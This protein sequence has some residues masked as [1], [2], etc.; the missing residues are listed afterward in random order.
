MNNQ[1]DKPYDDI[2][3]LPHPTSARHPRMSLNDRAAQFAPF[4][5]LTGHEEAIEETARLTDRPIALTDEAKEAL[6]RTLRRLADRLSA[7][8]GRAEAPAPTVTATYFVP[9]SRKEGGVYRTVIGRVAEVDELKR[10]LV[11]E[12]GQRIRFSRLYSLKS[13][14]Y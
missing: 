6:D 11:L 7:G 10:E 9:D 2:I 4:A 8:E 5:A 13:I 3:D 12:G 1:P 14:E